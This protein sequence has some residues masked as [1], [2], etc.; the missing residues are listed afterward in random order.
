M[1]F[2]PPPWLRPAI[3]GDKEVFPLARPP[4]QN[5]R[6]RPLGSSDCASDIVPRLCLCHAPVGPS[7]YVIVRVSLS[8]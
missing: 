4:A 6:V 2:L 7:V 5:A 1:L 8:A 3:G